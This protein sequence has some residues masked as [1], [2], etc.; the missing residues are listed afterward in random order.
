[1]S[2]PL[3][4]SNLAFWSAQVALLVLAAEL[5]VQLLRI[6]QPSA[7][8]CFWRTL[9]AVNL[10]LPLLEPWHRPQYLG[11][12]AP[13]LSL[14][15]IL[16]TYSP[17]P[18]SWHFPSFL[19]AQVLGLVILIGIVV[20]VALLVLGLLKLQQFRRASLPLPVDE[21]SAAALERVRVLVGVRAEF[22]VSSSVVSPV[23]FG[24]A[25]PAILLPER[26]LHM[27]PQSQSAIAC[28]EL[29]HVRRHDWGQHVVEEILRAVLWFHPAVAWL[30][31]RIRLARE[32]VVDLDVVKITEAR[33]PYL[34]A[35]LEFTS[36]RSRIR[37]IPAPPF[38]VE[39]QFAGRVA[40]ILKEVR[41]SRKRL[42]VS[43][44]VIVSSLA[45]AAVL[46]ARA[47]PLKGAPLAPQNPP[48][49]G[50]AQGMSGGVTGGVAEEF[51]GG[52][53]PGVIGGVPGGVAQG[54]SGG[55]GNEPV[56]DSSTL[57]LATVKRDLMVLRVRGLGTLVRAGGS[58]NLVA[59]VS[60]PQVQAKDIKVDQNA[61][62]TVAK[63][64]VKGHV[65]SVSREVSDG[66]RTVDV[67]LDSPLPKEAGVNSPIEGVIDIDNL[68]NVLNVGRP[69]RASANSQMALFKVAA[70]GAEAER[71]NV[72]VGRASVTQ[73]EVISG[74]NAGD[75]IILSDMSQWDKFDRIR[76]QPPIKSAHPTAEHE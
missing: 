12:A 9:L 23:T 31:A 59:R 27:Q 64:S 76:I 74:L 62:V 5:L 24:L 29:L 55:V 73:I 44:A 43:L 61:E 25:H 19:V 3:W 72:Q 34:Q 32:Q 7:L 38:L 37:A 22:R 6:R 49:T 4:F 42:I 33:K 17:A 51:A 52:V 36:G 30:I 57:W 67:A 60:F 66:V 45:L 18:S 39:R 15:R 48:R 46:A 40:L 35:L 47:F 1:M 41:M 63:V 68:E 65:S 21:D 2:V 10:L 58:A 71:T 75:T 26:F 13:D 14:V 54:V 11:L 53:V 8:V 69:A 50:V 56:V 20:R 28:H 70:N 16:Q